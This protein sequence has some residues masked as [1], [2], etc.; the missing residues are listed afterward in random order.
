MT[1]VPRN[2][3]PL[4]A[5]QAVFCT[6]DDGYRGFWHGQTPTDDEYTYKYSGGLGTYPHQHRPFAIYSPEAEKTYFCW[7]GTPK[8]GHLGSRNMGYGPNQLLHMVSYYDHRTGLV[9]RPTILL[10]KYCGDAHDNPVISLDEQGHIW[11]FSP[12]H[13]QFTTQSFIHRSARP[14]DIDRFETVSADWLY[15]YPQ[16]CHREGGFI[17]MHTIYDNGR[18]L[19]CATSRDGYRW[20]QAVHLAEIEQG[21]YQVTAT[22]GAVTGTAFNY[23]PVEGGLEARTNL[24]FMQSADNGQTWTTVDGQ[25]LDL[26]LTRIDNPALVHDYRPEGL[27]VYMKDLVFHHAGHPIIVYITSRG[28]LPGPQNDPRTWMTARWTG[29]EWAIH[30]ILTS[31]N[32]Y[33]MGPLYLE[34][35]LWKLIA[36]ALPG[37]YPYNPGGEVGM[38]MSD[39]LG[40]SWTLRKQLTQNSARNHTFVRRP[41]NAHPDFYA[42]WAD[43][44]PRAPSSSFL[45]FTNRNGDHVWRLPPVMRDDYAKAEMIG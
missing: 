29:S 40:Q 36:P 18:K 2:T 17:M 37:A 23:H 41:V 39:D 7:G 44:N 31:D 21:H 45:Y 25:A 34:D 19:R 14:Y 30:P 8:N 12:S 9:P 32:N 15:A 1:G 5:E 27:L 24:Y 33:D 10:D 3:M 6:K 22:H 4:P 11:I 35:G 26:P 16:V 43:G 28:N 13:G 38:W 42:F 20:T